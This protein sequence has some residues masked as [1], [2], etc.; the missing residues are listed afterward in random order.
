MI[1]YAAADGIR[2]PLQLLAEGRVHL[3]EKSEYNLI[4]QGGSHRKIHH[5]VSESYS[6]VQ[7]EVEEN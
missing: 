5:T 3:V 2:F 6:L 7:T 4:H 1:H